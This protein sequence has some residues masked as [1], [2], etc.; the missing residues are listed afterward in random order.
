MRQAQG[1]IVPNPSNCPECG[2]NNLYSSV[3]VASGGGHAPNYLPGLGSFFS[4]AKFTLVIC[5]DCGLARY[6]ASPEARAKLAE[7]SKWRKV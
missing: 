5:K 6:F 7:S 4:A 3:E 1:N 2:R